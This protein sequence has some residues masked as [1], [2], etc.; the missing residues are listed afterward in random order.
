MVL[1]FFVAY[2]FSSMLGPGQHSTFFCCMHRKQWDI[3]SYYIN[4]NNNIAML[5][6]KEIKTN[7]IK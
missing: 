6:L 5:S 1:L 3:T 4:H 7:T 2:S